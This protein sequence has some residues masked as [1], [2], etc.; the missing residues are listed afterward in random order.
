MANHIP[1]EAAADYEESGPRGRTL[2]GG[3]TQRPGEICASSSE[4]DDRFSR[5]ARARASGTV[6]AESF[7]NDAGRETTGAAPR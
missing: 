2:L 4:R 5:N 6:V 3:F 1:A 7:G